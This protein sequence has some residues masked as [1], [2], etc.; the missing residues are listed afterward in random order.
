MPY[1]DPEKNKQY[2]NNYYKKHRIGILSKLKKFRDENPELVSARK[3]KERK[4]TKIIVLS[5]YSNLIPEC[6]CCGEKQLKF[7]TI[8]HIDGCN[9]Q[10]R[11]IH[12]QGARFYDWLKARKFPDGFQVLCF[13]C[14]SGRSI[15]GGICPHEV[16]K[17]LIN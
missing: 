3:K 7:L 11:K 15:N 16:N 6:L 12:G 8:D 2:K 5:H 4:K 13:N 17:N 9:K 1:K 14:N 10:Q